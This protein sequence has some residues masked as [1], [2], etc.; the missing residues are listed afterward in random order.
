ML[1]IFSQFRLILHW[2]VRATFKGEVRYQMKGLF[3]VYDIYSHCDYVGLRD[4]YETRGSG[5]GFV[6]AWQG[7]PKLLIARKNDQGELVQVVSDSMLIA[8]PK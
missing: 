3:S 4:P 5:A 2:S 7:H 8:V 6:L 1:L